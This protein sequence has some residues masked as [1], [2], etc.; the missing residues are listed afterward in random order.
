MTAQAGRDSHA[1]AAQH[2]FELQSVDSSFP[3]EVIIGDD[4]CFLR[5]GGH[6]L[7]SPRPLL[8]LRASVEVVVAIVAR[9][10]VKPLFVVASMQADIAN[11]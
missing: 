3:F 7:D 5:F 1:S 8:Q 6:G 9:I 2:A 11:G 4:K 10:A